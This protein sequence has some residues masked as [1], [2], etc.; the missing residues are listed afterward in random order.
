MSTRSNVL[1][2]AIFGL[3]VTRAPRWVR[4]V[5][6]FMAVG[7]LLAIAVIVLAVTASAADSLPSAGKSRN[8]ARW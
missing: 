5:L 4:S 2:V 3:L 6:A 7:A 8:G 1:R